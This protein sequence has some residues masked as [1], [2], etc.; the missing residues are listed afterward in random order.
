M[1]RWMRLCWSCL[2]DSD[3]YCRGLEVVVCIDSCP[4]DLRSSSKD[5]R[6]VDGVVGSM[7]TGLYSP[8]C[9]IVS[10]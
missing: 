4:I 7:M 10:G 2:G 6:G 8:W 3:G 9:E 1:G 5:G